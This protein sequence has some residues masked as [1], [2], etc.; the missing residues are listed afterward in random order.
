[1]IKSIEKVTIPYYYVTLSEDYW[2][3]YYRTTDGKNWEADFG[4][5]WECMDP[6]QEIIEDFIQSLE[7]INSL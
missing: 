7:E 6:P 4:M 3:N 1:M 5:C 2:P